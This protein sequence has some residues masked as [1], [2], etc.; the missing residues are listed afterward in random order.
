M[1]LATLGW[2]CWWIEL[3]LVRFA[4]EVA[5]SPMVVAFVAGVPG[6]LGLVLALL[7]VRVT[8]SWLP[9]LLIA[10]FANGGLIVLPWLAR[11]L[12]IDFPG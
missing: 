1:G 5:P 8:R 2:A 4:P 10:L 3:F 7:S 11:G 9:F 6:T 12:E